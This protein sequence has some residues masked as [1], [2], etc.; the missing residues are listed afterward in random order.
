MK[1]HLKIL[2]LL[3]ITVA[4]FSFLNKEDKS[5][6]PSKTITHE[7]AKEMQDR[8]VE[9]RYEIITS[10]LGPDTR[11]FYWSLED[12]EQYLAYVKK[13]SQKQGVKNPG[14]RIYLGAYGEEKGGKTTL[15]FSPTKDVISAENKGEAPLNNY[16]ILP[17]NTG[18]GLWPPGSYDPGNP[19]GEEEIALN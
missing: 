16:D 14:I 7:A 13:E 8:Y 4:L 9:T 19:Y 5:E 18:S 3:V 6:L 1:N 12:L 11:E 10:Q 2:G 17:M 15:F